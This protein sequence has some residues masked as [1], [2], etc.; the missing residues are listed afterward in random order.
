[1]PTSFRHKSP[2]WLR[3]LPFRDKRR[4]RRYDPLP[5]MSADVAG[6]KN[7]IAL[8]WALALGTITAT[9]MGVIIYFISRR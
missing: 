8:I 1:M 2:R 4:L 7:R 6:A 5:G 9:I 3:W